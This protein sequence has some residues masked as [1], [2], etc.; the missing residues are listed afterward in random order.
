[1]ALTAKIQFGDFQ[2]PVELAMEIIRLLDTRVGT[3]SVLVEPTCGIGNFLAA[4]SEAFGPN[5]RYFGFD[6]NQ[7]HVNEAANRLKSDEGAKFDIRCEDFYARDWREFFKRFTAENL[8]I[9]GNPPWVTNSTLGAIGGNN[10]PT[11]QNFQRLAGFDARSGK[12]NF[13]ISEWMIIKLLEGLN[14]IPATVAMLCKT[15]T[16]RRVLKHAWLNRLDIS[17]A[18]VHLFDT[19][20]SFNVSVSA[21]LLVVRT[22]ATAT[23]MVTEASVY[24]DMSAD[25]RRTR[26]GLTGGELTADLDLFDEC[27]DIDGFSYRTWRSGIK[28]DAT[29]IMEF[30][31][32]GSYCV[33][34]LGERCDLETTYLYPLLKSS[35]L[36]NARLEPT[37]F[38]LVT[39]RFIGEDT[40]IIEQTAPKTWQYLLDH[41]VYL[42]G[43]KSSIYK[44]TPRFGIFGVGGYS[45]SPWKVAISGLYKSLEFRVIG[46]REDKPVILDDTCY[47]MPCESQ[48]EAEFAC[49]LLNSDV[50][51]TFVQALVFSDAKRPITVDVLKRIDLKKVSSRLGLTEK[52]R[53]YF[54]RDVFNNGAQG[55]FVFERQPDYLGMKRR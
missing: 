33:N 10:L 20:K 25:G 48:E 41:A 49:S 16:A 11:K 46:F 1:M 37:K 50:S 42:D 31:Q 12:S 14:G 23:D 53:Q 21:C 3:P 45:F 30:T 36:A 26:F 19:K 32:D 43:R 13:D 44:G 17:D 27:R 8:L 18:A 38:V 4:A 24:P 9:V 54:V 29:K 34:K 5:T 28:H 47:F 40:G 6:I 51:R 7:Q 52:A 2:T 22:G 35:D 15:A 55:Q 39:Q